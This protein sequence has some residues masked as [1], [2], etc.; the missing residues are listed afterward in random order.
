MTTLG[1]AA[2]FLRLL[3]HLYPVAQAVPMAAV[4]V[5]AVHTVEVGVGVVADAAW[6]MFVTITPLHLEF[7]GLV[8]LPV[9]Y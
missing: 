6:N 5:L 3:S 1:A 4:T 2:E 7:P 8:M 9:H